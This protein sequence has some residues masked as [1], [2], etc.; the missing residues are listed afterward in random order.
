IDKFSPAMTTLPILFPSL[1]PPNSIN[2]RSPFPLLHIQTLQFCSVKSIQKNPSTSTS[3][4]FYK[5]PSSIFPAESQDEDEDEDEDDEDDDD[6]EAAEDYDDVYA[7]VSDGGEDSED[8][9][10]SSVSSEILNIEESRRQRVE[11][12]RNE[13]REFGDGIIDV[14]ELA[15]IYSF[16][17]DKFQRLSIQAFLRGSSVVVS[18]PTSSGKTL[19][20][21]AAAVATV[22]RGRR[23]F[24]TTPL[25]ALSNQKFREFCETFGD[26]NVGLL[27]GDSAVNRDAQILIMTT[28]ILRNMLYQRLFIAQRKFN[29]FVFQRL[30]LIQMSWLDGLVRFMVG[31]SW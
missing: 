9:L 22:S 27:T 17:I 16:R 24:Y 5:F 20:A 1:S 18:A 29:L 26:S 3:K 7:E 30:L 15:S 12:L 28:E 11:K 14:N 2:S 31:R 8:E 25:K 23:L 21:E 10:E 4:I 19:I 6:E 13:V